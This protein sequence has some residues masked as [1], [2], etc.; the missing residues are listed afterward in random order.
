[1]WALN[2]QMLRPTEVLIIDDG[3][4]PESFD[5]MRRVV[6]CELKI[7]F[8]IVRQDNRG[9]SGVRN[10]ALEEIATP[11]FINLDS[12]NVPFPDF[13]LRLVTGLERAPDAVACV[14]YYLGTE[15]DSEGR[16]TSHFHYAPLGDGRALGLRKNCFGDNNAA[17]RT[18]ELR[19]AGGWDATDRSGMEDY[20]LFMSLI[21]RGKKLAVV[22]KPLLLYRRHHQSVTR[23]ASRLPAEIK[24]LRNAK[25]TDPLTA[26]S[27]R[28]FMRGTRQELAELQLESSLGRKFVR[29]VTIVMGLDKNISIP[30]RSRL[31]RSIR[32]RFAQWFGRP[33]GTR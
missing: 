14:P 15:F 1:M 12:D 26:L 19:A 4:R 33:R 27:I 6:E 20:A 24:L 9:V 5:G 22:P 10:R 29:L 25:F 31:P 18:Q 17:Y 8:R 32:R 16:E 11:L 21:S 23:T 30:T 28:Q 2:S 3:S 13:C 7:P